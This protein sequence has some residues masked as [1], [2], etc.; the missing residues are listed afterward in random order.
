MALIA[1]AYQFVRVL[2]RRRLTFEDLRVMAVFT[3]LIVT[4]SILLVIKFL[5]SQ[6]RNDQLIQKIPGP[7]G[8]PL[9]GNAISLNVN[10]TGIYFSFLL[11]SFS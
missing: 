10:L 9:V 6:S 11:D 8:L 3:L 4:V 7:R 5:L 2:C 1:Y